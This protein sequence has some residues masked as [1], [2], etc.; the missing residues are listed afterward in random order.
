MGK[1]LSLAD[2]LQRR[3]APATAGTDRAALLQRGF[4]A[5][6]GLDDAALRAVVERLE[7]LPHGAALVLAGNSLEEASDRRSKVRRRVRE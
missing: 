7:R 3:D 2:A 6:Y 4:V 5:L 1:V